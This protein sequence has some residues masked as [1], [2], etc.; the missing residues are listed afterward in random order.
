VFDIDIAIF[1][2]KEKDER[3]LTKAIVIHLALFYQCD[4]EE[5]LVLYL[6]EK[7]SKEVGEYELALKA[8]QVAEEQIRYHVQQKKITS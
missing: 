6:N 2:K 7:I 8:M 4:S 1:S 5:L 3:P